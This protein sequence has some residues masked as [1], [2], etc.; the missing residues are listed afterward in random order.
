MYIYP[1]LPEG[2]FYIDTPIIEGCY[3]TSDYYPGDDIYMCD[4][5]VVTK[6]IYDFLVEND[7]TILV[8]TR[9]RKVLFNSFLRNLVPTE[10]SISGNKHGNYILSGFTDATIDIKSEYKLMPN[11]SYYFRC[12]SKTAISKFKIKYCSF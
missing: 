6:E 12:E 5:F 7:I 2:Y 4:K 11:I 3:P 1:K 8:G 10:Y 9:F